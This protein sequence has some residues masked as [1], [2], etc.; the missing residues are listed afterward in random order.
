[1]EHDR[2]RG[3]GTL[4]A[5]VGKD[6]A[7]LARE[8]L[9]GMT[10]TIEALR[11]LP[12]VAEVTVANPQQNPPHRIIHILSWHALQLEHFAADLRASG[13]APAGRGAPFSRCCR[14]CIVA[15]SF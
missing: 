3:A 7:K 13:E 14:W 11:Q 8:L 1:M 10:L 4:D 9:T 12:G 5:E 15:S 2:A 6:E